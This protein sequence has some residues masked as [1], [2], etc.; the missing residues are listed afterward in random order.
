[1]FKVNQGHQSWYGGTDQKPIC[2]FLYSD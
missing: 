1:M 2:D